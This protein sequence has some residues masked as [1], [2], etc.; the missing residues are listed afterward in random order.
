MHTNRSELAYDTA[1]D[2]LSSALKFG[3]H[4]SLE[5]IRRL[6][7]ALGN[8]QSSY[9]SVQVAGTN[10]KSSTSRM[11]AA[12]LRAEGFRVGLFTSP[13]LVE[14]PERF[15]I[16]GKVISHS[17]FAEIIDRVRYCAE[18]LSAKDEGAHAV[19]PV[20]ISR[21]SNA[22]GARQAEAVSRGTNRR[23][24]Q[25]RQVVYDSSEDSTTFTEFEYLTAAAFELFARQCV[26]F[27]VFEV[28]LGGRWDATSLLD[29]AVATICGIGLDHQGILGDTLEEIAAEKAAIIKPATSVVL[30]EQTHE[31]Q[32]VFMKQ[33][34][35]CATYAIAVQ[36]KG[37]EL[38]PALPEE[39]KVR[40]SVKSQF[41]GLVLRIY[42]RHDVYD[43][44]S[45]PDAPGYQAANAACAVASAEAA[46]GRSLSKEAVRQ[47]LHDVRFPGRFETLS[48]DPLLIID[49]AHNPQS[50][51]V[52]AQAIDKRFA[53]SKRPVLLLAVLSDKDARGIIAELGSHVSSVVAT[54]TS[55]PRAIPA[56]ELARI[57]E[58]VLGMLP[59]HYDNPS[60]AL[61]VIFSR[62]GCNSVVASG[63]ITLAGEIKGL[64]T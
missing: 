51:H 1:V 6:A 22:E 57:A 33:V 63:S 50:A 3:I 34:D 56:E 53:G 64:F 14:Y 28:G 59:V 29:P 36:P 52:L 19:S 25:S 43:G 21:R 42:G 4:P 10:G 35:S 58:E 17:V 30:G 46:L 26:D 62:D 31:V 61:H 11:I 37:E 5:G 40:F 9:V 49:G 15:E 16:D 20:D 44:I 32:Q 55:S 47:A 48:Q 60:E 38:F 27:A 41:D 23:I 24:T 12:L 13:E 2:F 7:D 45:M 54:Q 39:L 18:P 8:P